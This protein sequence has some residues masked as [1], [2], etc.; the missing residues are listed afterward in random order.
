ML[1][2]FSLVIAMFMSFMFVSE[3]RLSAQNAYD[4]DGKKLGHGLLQ[5]T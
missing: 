5:A 1:K 2:K 4:A 3:G